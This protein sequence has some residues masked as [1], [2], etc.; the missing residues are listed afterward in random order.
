MNSQ[1]PLTEGTKKTRNFHMRSVSLK[2]SL[3]NDE[4]SKMEIFKAIDS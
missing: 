4:I 1:R 3:L 2:N